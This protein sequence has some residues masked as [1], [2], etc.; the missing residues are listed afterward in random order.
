MDIIA[1]KIVQNW[2]IKKRENVKRGKI[3][4]EEKERKCFGAGIGV[5]W[6]LGK[7]GNRLIRVETTL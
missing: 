7:M 2:N 4:K 5:G 1:K 6:E 3:E